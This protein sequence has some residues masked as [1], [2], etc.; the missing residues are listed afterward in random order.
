MNQVQ[1]QENMMHEH[2]AT[3]TVLNNWYS[4]LGAE[5]LTFTYPNKLWSLW[6]NNPFVVSPDTSVHM[7]SCKF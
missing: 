5:Y 7:V 2:D 4:V 3:T 6:P 1:W